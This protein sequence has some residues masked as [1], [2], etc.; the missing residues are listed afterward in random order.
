M[1][2]PSGKRLVAMRSMV[3]QRGFDLLMSVFANLH[4]AFNDG[5]LIIL[6]SGTLEAELKQEAIRLK[7]TFSYDVFE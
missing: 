3:P 7:N 5:S 1:E 4:K 6:G 2:L